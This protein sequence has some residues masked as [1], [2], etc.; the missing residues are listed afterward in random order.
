DL[1]LRC[2]ESF[3]TGERRRVQRKFLLRWPEPSDRAGQHWGCAQSNSNT[4]PAD[5]IVADTDRAT[6]QYRYAN[7]SA[8]R[9]AHGNA[10]ADSN[11][12]ANSATVRARD[13]HAKRWSEL[14]R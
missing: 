13:F 7:G 11:P 9:H 1:H 8:A 12:N 6:H 4:D 3:A 10:N 5:F 2:A 14:E